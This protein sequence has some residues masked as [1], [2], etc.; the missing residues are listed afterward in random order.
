ME[1]AVIEGD[2][3]PCEAFDETV[4]LLGEIAGSGGRADVFAGEE[5]AEVAVVGM[6][7]ILAL[8]KAKGGFANR[9]A[10][11]VFGMFGEK[12]GEDGLA[13]V[14]ERAEE[15]EHGVGLVAGARGSG[16]GWRSRQGRC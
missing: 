16:N 7:A 12:G 1:F 6:L 5:S 2:G 4:E 15:T 10:F 8:S 14:V 3:F 13:W 9:G 11:L